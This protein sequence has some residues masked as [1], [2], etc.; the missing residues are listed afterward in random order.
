MICTFFVYKFFCF[1]VDFTIVVLFT[2]QLLYIM[3][4]WSLSYLLSL[5]FF[6]R[7]LDLSLT[8]ICP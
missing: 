5:T 2:A 6:V 4:L 3:F 1:N 8:F 7:D